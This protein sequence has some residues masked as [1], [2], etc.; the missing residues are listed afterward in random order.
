[1]NTTVKIES[2]NHKY[3]N[4]YGGYIKASDFL[5]MTLEESAERIAKAERFNRGCSNGTLKM[6]SWIR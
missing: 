4:S 6:T 1:M 2:R 5:F 3:Q